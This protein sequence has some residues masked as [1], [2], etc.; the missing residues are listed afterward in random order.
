MALAIAVT[1]DATPLDVP[2]NETGEMSE[3]HKTPDQTTSETTQPG[4]KPDTRVKGRCNSLKQD[5]KYPPLPGEFYCSRHLHTPHMRP[6]AEQKITEAQRKLDFLGV[7]LGDT[8]A[9]AA[10]LLRKAETAFDVEEFSAAYHFA[11]Q[12]IGKALELNGRP[13]VERAIVLRDEF[14]FLD[15]KASDLATQA[16]SEAKKP[17]PNWPQASILAAG[18]INALQPYQD[19]AER[20]RQE[21]QR[22]AEET[23]IQQ[24][25]AKADRDAREATER[26][27]RDQ[28]T[29][30]A[31]SS[32]GTVPVNTGKM[33][34]EQQR[35]ADDLSRKAQGKTDKGEETQSKDGK[36]KSS[37][38]KK[39]R[40][41]SDK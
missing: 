25:R 6:H 13:R 26:A 22:Q 27:E 21:R 28:R 36:K 2:A 7:G 23:R 20:N 39:K 31:L 11:L 10:N 35:I 4:K 5:C 1:S 32:V 14:G 37:K 15:K 12:A 19:R 40:Q 8:F 17:R 9:P 18:A 3:V 24:A 33:S 30:Q 41:P 38:G 29:A 16:E 34:A